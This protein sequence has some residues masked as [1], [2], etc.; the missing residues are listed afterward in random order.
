MATRGPVRARDGCC[1]IA[2]TG[3]CYLSR[4]SPTQARA[5]GET[6]KHTGCLAERGVTGFRRGSRTI[7]W[8]AP[9]QR[10]L[11]ARPPCGWCGDGGSASR[12]CPEPRSTSPA[13]LD[14]V[15]G[16]VAGTDGVWDPRKIK[17]A[18]TSKASR[19][20]SRSVSRGRR[21]APSVATRPSPRASV[22][23]ILGT[24]LT[25][26]RIYKVVH[27]R[28]FIQIFLLPFPHARR[29]AGLMHRVQDACNVGLEREG[30]VDQVAAPLGA[31]TPRGR[32][33]ES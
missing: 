27:S 17:S 4:L 14:T 5:G 33:G 10:V 9:T 23:R 13:D 26:S 6:Q 24:Y 30:L 1:G 29:T 28:L 19:S 7:L 2:G 20:S 22:R 21:E 15:D 25:E 8:I 18:P 12:G 31:D 3:H 32:L 16:G 11:C